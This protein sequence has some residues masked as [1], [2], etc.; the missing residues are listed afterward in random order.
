MHN[1]MVQV[2]ENPSKDEAEMDV[3]VSSKE[4]LLGE[5]VVRGSLGCSDR[6]VVVVKIQ[7]TVGI[8]KQQR[9]DPRL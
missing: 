4:E 1:C 2:L 8:K 7:G 9:T 3:L 5:V 6:E